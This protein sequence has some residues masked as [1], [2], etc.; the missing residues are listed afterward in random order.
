MKPIATP[1]KMLTGIT[2]WRGKLPGSPG[3]RKGEEASRY[4]GKRSEVCQHYPT[5]TERHPRSAPRRPVC[6]RAGAEPPSCAEVSP[7]GCRRRCSSARAG[8]D[9]APAG[10]VNALLEVDLRGNED[11]CEGAPVETTRRAPS[12][13]CL[14][15]SARTVTRKPRRRRKSTSTAISA[16]AFPG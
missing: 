2:S 10:R 14:M 15:R 13:L 11:K 16:A 3:R 7:A 4:R 8:P 6:L 12:S 9:L 5:A 1:N